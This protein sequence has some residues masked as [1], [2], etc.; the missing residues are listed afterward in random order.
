M[1]TEKMFVITKNWIN[2]N[3]TAKGAFTRKQ[4]QAL[5]IEWP[6]VKG[7][8]NE[9][10]G[11]LITFD[12]KRQFEMSS[13]CYAKGKVKDHLSLAVSLVLDNVSKLTDKQ[14]AQ[15]IEAIK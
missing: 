11:S 15:L 10:C 9:I 2:F 8:I 1:S 14:K 3:R 12:Q 5:Y 7:W 13:S 6:P 4:I